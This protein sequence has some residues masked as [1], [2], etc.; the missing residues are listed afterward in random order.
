MGFL[1]IGSA[2]RAT[3]GATANNVNIAAANTK[4]TFVNDQYG[5]D[6][7]QL[8]NFYNTVMG[9]AA[10]TGTATNAG[11]ANLAGNTQLAP[12]AQVQAANAGAAPLASSQNASAAGTAAANAGNA[13]MSRAANINTANNNQD[14]AAQQ[15]LN[16]QLTGIANGQA[17]SAGQLQFQQSQAANIAA[18]NAA[19]QSGRTG[20]N[21]QLI[22]RNLAGNLA[23]QNSTAAAQ[24]AQLSLQQQQAA[25]QQLASNLGTMAGQDA[26]LA[27]SQ[28]G[29][30]Q[31]TGLAN[32]AAINAQ[33]AL[34]SG[35]QQQANLQGSAQAQQAAL[36]NAQLGTQTN[37]ANQAALQNQA[38]YN[39][40]LQQQAA[41]ANQGALNT[42]ASQQGSLN[43]QTALANQAAINAQNQYN[44][45]NAQNMTLANMQSQG[46]QNQLA[47]QAGLS[48]LGG[49]N[50][51]DQLQVQNEE[52]GLQAEQAEEQITNNF[53]QGQTSAVMSGIGQIAG[54]IGGAIGGIAALS[55]KTK[56]K[57][58]KKKSAAKQ[59]EAL[60]D[61]LHSSGKKVSDANLKQNITTSFNDNP[62]NKIIAPMQ[63][64]QQQGGGGFGVQQ[65]IQL[66]AAIKKL[67]TPNAPATPSTPS[68]PVSAPGYAA[69]SSNVA[70][71]NSYVPPNAAVPAP[72]A[73]AGYENLS[74]PAV[75]M[76]G[77]N[78]SDERDKDGKRSVSNALGDMLDKLTAYQYQYKDSAAGLPGVTPGEHIGV[79][80]QDLEKSPAG[81]TFVDETPEG[82]KVVN[83][84]E[85]LPALLASMAMLHKRTK[86][87]EAHA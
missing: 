24:G 3:P 73:T 45:T 10:P 59:L 12:A 18:Q 26:G 50:S 81:K 20:Q 27:T 69:P 51:L 53:N 33:S 39:A 19:A 28:A 11:A 16:A 55:D 57:N 83:Y 52:A 5:N 6:R 43:Q 41:L 85:M 4:N 74:S 56:K 25:Q 75:S 63:Q 9:Q 31:Q 23:G 65:G 21:A 2:P 66:G 87:L 67:G 72:S 44:A 54:G 62:F 64:P 30:Q 8:N 13:A 80:A 46:N 32:Q 1:G 48:A 47:A 68:A 15:A 7:N 14:R 40:N 77:N 58:I 76:P 82:H 60:L 78:I 34:N 37:L 17:P 84:G 38:Q 35:Y 29:L 86:K 22:A 61:T 79:M 70:P 49:I 42:M 71:N 36:Q